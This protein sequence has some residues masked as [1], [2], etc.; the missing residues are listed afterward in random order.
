MCVCVCV[1]SVD[2]APR[3]THLLSPPPSSPPPPP[4]QVKQNNT[5]L[6][7]RRL[8]A[9]AHFVPASAFA[10]RKQFFLNKE[11]GVLCEKMEVNN[12]NN[13]FFPS[14]ATPFL[15]YVNT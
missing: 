3:P 4:C 5:L 8:R 14:V 13:P 6:R 1:V 11:T 12:P 9:N 2:A 7:A 10:S 15:P